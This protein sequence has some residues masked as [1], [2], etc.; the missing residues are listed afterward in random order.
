MVHIFFLFP[1]ELRADRVERVAPELMLA[2]HVLQH[3][4]L[5]SSGESCFFRFTLPKGL[6]G[7]MG[8]FGLSLFVYMDVSMNLSNAE[9]CDP[10]LILPNRGNSFAFKVCARSRR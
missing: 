6:G 9:D 10:L 8:V 2:L 3:I 7:K 5:Q 1:K 4:D